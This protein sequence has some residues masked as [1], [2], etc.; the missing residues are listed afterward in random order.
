MTKQARRK[1]AKKRLII[2]KTKRYT[3]A[4]CL[5]VWRLVLFTLMLLLLLFCTAWI[6][7]LR[8]FNAQHISEVI[9]TQLQKQLN[10]P[11]KISSLEFKFVNTL[12]LK[13]FYILDTEGDPGQAL[14]SAD[15]VTLRFALIPL[16]E[17]KLVIHEV[18]FNSPRF[19]LVRSENG[20]Y[21]IPHIRMSRSEPSTYTSASGR[22]FE[23][24]VEDW[25]VRNGIFNFKDQKSG[26]SHSLYGFNAHFDNLHFNE[27][28]HFNLSMI[29]RNQWQGNISELEINMDGQVNFA[30]LNWSNFALHDVRTQISLFSEPVEI[31]LNLSNLRK[32]SFSL[33]LSAPAFKAE[34]LSQFGIQNMDFEVPASKFQVQGNLSDGYS[35]LEIPHLTA[36]IGDIN[37]TGNGRADFASAPFTMHLNFDTDWFSLEGKERLLP[38]LADYHLS[39]KGRVA[40]TLTHQQG[41]FTWPSLTAQAKNV[42]GNFYGFQTR[43]L[44]AEFQAKNNFDDLYGRTSG[45]F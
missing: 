6:F 34:N 16:L 14:V 23:V 17:Q 40:G 24:S 36:T 27:L 43:A 22:K 28:S 21:N 18:S 11:V 32:P 33:D 20:F 2:R 38:L 25:N 7:F 13:G 19:N 26:A 39:G 35:K 10:R 9:T 3:K 8:A 12:E 30:D 1:Q 5:T 41:L 45:G 31:I 42:T 37:I 44:N 29:L 4:S 15:S